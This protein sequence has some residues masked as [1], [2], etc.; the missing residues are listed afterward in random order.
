M[1]RPGMIMRWTGI[2]GCLAAAFLMVLGIW[3]PAK[4]GAL[5][6]YSYIDDQGN[7]MYTDAPETIPDKYRPRV[8]TH[9]QPDP[10]AK[11]TSIVDAVQR[12]VQDQAKKVGFTMPPLAF[13]M[14]GL[15]SAQSRILTYA[16]GAAL[17]LLVM[18]YLSKSQ[19]LRML[20]FCLLIALGIG[21]P[22]LMYVSDGGPMDAMTTK[23]TAAGQA[24]QDRLPQLPR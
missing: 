11:S 10:P 13:Q 17:A 9:I 19:L 4:A 7:P 22:V 6:I 24:Q 8:R 21:T 14:E 12:T 15:N 23:A 1:N 2:S 18:I 5:T 20:G 3:C 16:G